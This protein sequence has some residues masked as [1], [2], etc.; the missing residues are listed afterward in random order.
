MSNLRIE[1]FIPPK[2]ST[3]DRSRRER[4]IETKKHR[5]RLGFFRYISFFVHR[6]GAGGGTPGGTG[7]VPPPARGTRKPFTGRFSPLTGTF[8][9]SPTPSVLVK[10]ISPCY[11]TGLSFWCRWWDSKSVI[12]IGLLAL[13][14]AQSGLTRFPGR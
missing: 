9:S 12:G 5:Q 11:R 4:A 13:R 7:A 10:K 14:A 3:A 2:I 1:A 8:P 6:L